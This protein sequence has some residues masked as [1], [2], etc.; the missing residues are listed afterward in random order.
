MCVSHETIYKSLFIQIRGV[1]RQELKKHLR[2][3]GMFRHAKSHRVAGRGNIV[4]AI[5]IRERSAKQGCPS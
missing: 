4:D 2:T 1:L 3:K 5:S